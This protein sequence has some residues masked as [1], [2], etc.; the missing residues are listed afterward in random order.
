M[1]SVCGF[2]FVA[3]NVLQPFSQINHLNKSQTQMSCNQHDVNDEINKT[4]MKFVV[5]KY[6][7]PLTKLYKY[8]L[9]STHL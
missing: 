1:I 8:C 6:N 4:F 2:F 7:T 5:N 9:C 3:S